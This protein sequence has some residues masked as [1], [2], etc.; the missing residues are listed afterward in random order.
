MANYTMCGHKNMLT[1]DVTGQSTQKALYIMCNDAAHCQDFHFNNIV[2]SG[3]VS[4]Q[5]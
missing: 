1:C 2:L 3:A 5:Q 4:F